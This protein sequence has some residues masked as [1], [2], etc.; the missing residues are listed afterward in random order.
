MMGVFKSK[1][2]LIIFAR[3]TCTRMSEYMTEP[4]NAFNEHLIAVVSMKT[5]ALGVETSHPACSGGG[6]GSTEEPG[7]KGSHKI[8]GPGA[9]REMQIPWVICK[10]LFNRF[11][12]YCRIF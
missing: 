4:F 9:S 2:T 10:S 11:S 3:N 1:F 7:E 6:K 12:L 5:R 8:Q